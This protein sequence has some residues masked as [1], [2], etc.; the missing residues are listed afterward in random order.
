MS[1]CRS[2]KLVFVSRA[3]Y[4]HYRYSHGVAALCHS[5]TLPPPHTAFGC[6]TTR[7]L[8]PLRGPRTTTAMRCA[9]RR[10]RWC[11]VDVT[12]FTAGA[13]TGCGR[14]TVAAC[15]GCRFF[16]GW[17]QRPGPGPCSH[18]RRG[19]A[20]R[21]S[22]RVA[23]A[24]HPCAGGSA[25]ASGNARGR[26]R[27]PSQNSGRGRVPAGFRRRRGSGG[28]AG[29]AAL[30]LRLVAHELLPVLQQLAAHWL[31]LL[32]Q[33]VRALAAQPNVQQAVDDLDQL[34]LLLH[35]QVWCLQRRLH[36]C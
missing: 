10:R 14:I 17:P 33:C 1:S 11:A 32:R 34:V 9:R 18:L 6:I 21:H 28:C 12:G 29:G 3:L 31:D 20:A 5:L 8:H 23:C 16:T 25:C 36:A 35:E 30:H 4:L 2:W 15:T 27:A 19:C 13:G 22:R 7:R 26:R 24:P